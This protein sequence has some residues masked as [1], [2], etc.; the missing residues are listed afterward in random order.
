M[1]PISYLSAP[2]LSSILHGI[3]RQA[4]KWQ[5]QT[6]V[7]LALLASTLGIALYLREKE[8]KDRRS[9]QCIADCD[10]LHCMRLIARL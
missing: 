4:R 2:A 9:F 5:R 3:D 8:V 1:L 6:L 10:L 7:D